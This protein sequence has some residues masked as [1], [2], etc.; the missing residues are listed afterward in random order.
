MFE[1]RTILLKII[2][3]LF[4]VII[5]TIALLIFMEI[6]DFPFYDRY[7]AGFFRRVLSI[8]GP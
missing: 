5:I 6:I 7:L 2:Y 8:F 4:F 1:K 3:Y